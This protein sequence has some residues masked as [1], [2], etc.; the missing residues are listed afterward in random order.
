VQ[1]LKHHQTAHSQTNQHAAQARQVTRSAAAFAED[2]T[3]ASADSC[4]ACSAPISCDKSPGG[5]EGPWS[6]ESTA[7]T[8]DSSWCCTWGVLGVGSDRDAC[9][10]LVSRAVP[11]LDSRPCAASAGHAATYRAASQTADRNA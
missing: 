4:N 3:H 8:A 10:A 1:K 2:A 11:P 9:R 7:F 5:R 6:A